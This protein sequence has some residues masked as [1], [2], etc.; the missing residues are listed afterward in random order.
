MGCFATFYNGL[1]PVQWCNNTIKQGIQ[2]ISLAGW[3]DKGKRAWQN[4]NSIHGP[5]RLKGDERLIK[6]MEEG[7]KRHKKVEDN[8]CG[9][10]RL[11]GRSGCW[12]FHRGVGEVRM[13]GWIYDTQRAR[14]SKWPSD[15]HPSCSPPPSTQWPLGCWSVIHFSVSIN[16][17]SEAWRFVSVQQNTRERQ[18]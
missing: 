14:I 1:E 9:G 15:K 13:K 4:T 16:I 6:E 5:S 10:S 11:E 2:A 12:S 3:S 7:W 18:W 8:M 17:T